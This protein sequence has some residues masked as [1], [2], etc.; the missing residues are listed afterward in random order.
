MPRQES[1]CISKRL[2]DFKQQRSP[3]DLLAAIWLVAMQGR[4][5]ELL[6]GLYCLIRF[7]PRRV[8]NAKKV[9]VHEL[10][11]LGEIEVLA[12][13]ARRQCEMAR[14]NAM[15]P[16]EA[17]LPY[18]RIHALAEYEA[19]TFLGEYAE[20]SARLYVRSPERVR[21]F[22]PYDRDPGVRHIHLVHAHNGA[23]YIATGDSRKYLDKFHYRGGQLHHIAR[24]KKWFG[25]FTAG[26]SIGGQLYLG[27]DFSGRPNYIYC[28]ETRERFPFPRPAFF[29]Y[30]A[31]MLPIEDRYII[32]V[33]RSLPYSAPQRVISIFDVVER[34]FIY[35]AQ[36]MRDAFSGD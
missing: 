7:R 33:N 26:C 21:I 35:S 24:V 10:I 14:T 12:R 22:A 9:D 19:H 15:T 25:G 2:A 5:H 17:C 6:F 30:C 36:C 8:K 32:C 27:T 34:Q 20:D 16:R 1:A 4:L 28:L 29:K 11:R 13:S 31:V 18:C 23:I 3:R